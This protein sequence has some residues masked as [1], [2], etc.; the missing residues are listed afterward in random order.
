VPMK[1]LAWDGVIVARLPVALQQVESGFPT[2]AKC[3][4]SF[5]IE[6]HVTRHDLDHIQ[7]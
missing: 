7:P 3:P 5:L 6:R 4:S 2:L 1:S